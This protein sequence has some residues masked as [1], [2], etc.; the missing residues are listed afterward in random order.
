MYPAQ[1]QKQH[2]TNKLKRIV[3]TLKQK[4]T[5]IER[6]ENGESTLRLAEKYGIG[7]QTVRDVL[8]NNQTKE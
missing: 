6:F 1:M 7:A 3:T 4:L 5:L 2:A 8:D